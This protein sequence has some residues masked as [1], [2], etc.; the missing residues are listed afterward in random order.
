M[1]AIPES[2]SAA[3]PSAAIPAATTAPGPWL[4]HVPVPLFAVIMGVTGLGIAW[5]KAGVTL[6]LP[7]MIGEAV[8]ALAALLFVVIAALYILKAVRH[9]AVVMQE[10]RHP[11]RAAFFPTISVG[12]LL[13]S[14]AATPH[15]RTVALAL[16]SVGAALHLGLTLILVGRWL[17]GP[18]EI[19]HSSPAWF[20]PVV[21][22]IIVP[23][24]GAPLGQNEASWFFYAIGLVFWGVLFT[25]I[26]YRLVFHAPLPAK[27]V[28]TLFILIAPPAMAFLATM[29]LG[30][31]HLT[32]FARILFH[33]G[34]FLTLLL[35]TLARTFLAV[36]FAVSWWAYTFPLDAIAVAALEYA[37]ASGGGAVL[38]GI[39]SVLLAVAT[40]VVGLVLVRTALAMGRRQLFI[41][42]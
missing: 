30:D 13:L 10:F 1:S 5:R 4:M 39:A 28:P 7:G 14:I 25:V 42:E 8:L 17:T 33:F 21:G 32:P 27:I 34:L 38:T 2:A 22:N 36:P 31:G 12:L 11:V 6:G 18:V 16:W 29:A 15:D 26:F 19:T 9:P 41:P 3:A 20:I 35:A 24:A 40:L 37:H 23:V